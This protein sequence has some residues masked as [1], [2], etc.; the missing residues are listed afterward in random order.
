MLPAG[1]INLGASF[2]LQAT[3][4]L[5]A[6]SFYRIEKLAEQSRIKPDQQLDPL[7]IIIPYFVS[8]VLLLS[9]LSFLYWVRIDPPQTFS[10][11]LSVM[12]VT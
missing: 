5:Q 7:D 2:E 10:I 4:F 11:S 9:T 12:A 1:R 6:S 3:R 8:C